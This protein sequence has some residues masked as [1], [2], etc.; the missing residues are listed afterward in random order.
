MESEDV[1]EGERGS[2][3]ST[4]LGNLKLADEAEEE[5]T[6][7]VLDGEGDVMTESLGEVTLL[8]QE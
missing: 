5:E 2:S 7:L 1:G 8:R 3:E 4:L 6:I